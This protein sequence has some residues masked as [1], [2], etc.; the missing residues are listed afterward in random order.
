MASKVYF[1]NLRTRGEKGNKANKVRELLDHVMSGSMVAE[2][3]LVAIKIHFGERGSDCFINPIFVRPVADRVK[4]MG[5]KPYLTDTNTLYSG[6]RHN[7]VDHTVTALEHGF[8]YTVTGAPVI[9]ADGLR[10]GNVK[11]VHVGCKH[12]ENVKMAR[13]LVE[14]DAMVVM[15]HFKGHELAGFGGAIKNLAMGG[16]PVQG[17]KEQHSVTICVDRSMCVGCGNCHDVCPEAAITLEGGKAELD[18]EACIGCGECMTVCPEDAIGMD[19]ETEIVPFMERMTEYALGVAKCF[20]GRACYITFLTDIT[21]DCDCT[22]WSDAPIVPD[23]GILASVD[24]VA[25]D[26]AGYDLVNAQRGFKDSLLQTCHEE[27][28]DKIAAL[29][30]ETEPTIQLSYGERIGLG[31]REYE[32][33]EL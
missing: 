12:F 28:C 22:S 25:I 18:H 26:Q 24:P 2:G 19:W 1:H 3:D 27:G 5:G 32:L 9:I 16:A 8:D 6:G 10:S 30:P 4:R 11:E 15:S 23:I 33:I 29:R 31:Y 13:D 14:A 21:P 17:K 20:E 7:S